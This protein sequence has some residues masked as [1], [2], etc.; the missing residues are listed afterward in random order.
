[1]AGSTAVVPEQLPEVESRVPLA[2]TRHMQPR[3]FVY[4]LESLAN[5]DRHYVGLT[6]DVR[7]R[8]QMHNDLRGI[9]TC[10]FGPWRLIVAI[11]FVDETHA[12]RFEEF[13]K[14][15]SGRAFARRHFG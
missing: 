15:G 4:V 1:M 2:G 7:K 3:R 5:P 12:V 14:S 10:K 6:A 9:H 13:L 8:L 11:E